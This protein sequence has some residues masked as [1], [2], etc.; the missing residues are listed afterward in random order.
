[1]LSYLVLKTVITEEQTQEL[2]LVEKFFLYWLIFLAPIFR[3]LRFISMPLLHLKRIQCNKDVK[4]F[5]LH[6]SYA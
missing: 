2:V 3:V 5:D 1:M 6:Y 4:Y